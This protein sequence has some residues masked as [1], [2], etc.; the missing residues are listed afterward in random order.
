MSGVPTA[1]AGSYLGEAA[2]LNSVCGKRTDALS[3]EIFSVCQEEQLHLEVYQRTDQVLRF[4]AGS[5]L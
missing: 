2:K 3:N 4:G 1:Q 5:I